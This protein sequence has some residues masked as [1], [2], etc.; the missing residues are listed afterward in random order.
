MIRVHLVNRDDR[1]WVDALP[2]VMLAYNEMEQGS[3]AIQPP[4]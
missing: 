1:G 4:K 3:M 2:G